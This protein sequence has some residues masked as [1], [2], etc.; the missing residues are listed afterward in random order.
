[1]ARSRVEVA[2][3]AGLLSAGAAGAGGKVSGK[4]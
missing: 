2:A 1:M 3:L 4:I